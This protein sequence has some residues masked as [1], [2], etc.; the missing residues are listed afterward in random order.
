MAAA[1]TEQ[2]KRLIVEDLDFPTPPGFDETTPPFKGGVEM[3]SFAAVELLYL[4][5]GSAGA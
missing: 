2:I 5:S 1:I 4:A 3:D